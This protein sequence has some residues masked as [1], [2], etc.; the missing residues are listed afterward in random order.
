MLNKHLL[1]GGVEASC[2]PEGRCTG[3]WDPWHEVQRRGPQTVGTSD[4]GLCPSQSSRARESVPRGTELDLEG[5]LRFVLQ[6]KTPQ[7][8]PRLISRCLWT[9]GLEWLDWFFGLGLSH[10][11]APGLGSPPG[12][13][14][15]RPRLRPPGLLAGF[16]S[17]QA[18]GQGHLPASCSTKTVKRGASRQTEWPS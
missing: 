3:P 17:L 15:G 11:T 13:E 16:P 6:N 12:V 1:S 7:T 14:Q 5:F 4:G 18:A 8:T 10:R 2:E 9:R